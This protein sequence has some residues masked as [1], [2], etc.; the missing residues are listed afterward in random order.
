MRTLK[1]TLAYDGTSYVGWQ[2]QE[3]G[4]SVQQVVEEALQ[5]MCGDEVA[6]VMGASRTDAGV[7]AL[8]QVASVRV[9]FAHEARA[10]HRALNVNLPPDVRAIDVADAPPGFHAQFDAVGKT[11][12]YRIATARVAS[13]FDRWFVWHM[14][15]PCD[16]DLMRAAAPALVGHHDFAAFQGRGSAI[17]DTSR[18]IRRIEIAQTADEI[19]IDIDGDGF[20]RH[21][22]RILVGTLVDIGIGARPFDTIE[23]ALAARARP[24]AGR[25]APA[26]GLTLV[27]VDY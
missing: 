17:V 13:P 27:R 9:R 25:T 14:P 19:R 5:P 24:A 26:A 18:T 2:R 10:V 23:R 12:R 8:A 6:V 16:V 3:N 11:Y 20:L 7:H 21:M 1:L 4:M 15:I 22:V